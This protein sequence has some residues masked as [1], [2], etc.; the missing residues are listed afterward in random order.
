ME[1]NLSRYLRSFPLASA[2]SMH[3]AID[4]QND[5]SNCELVDLGSKRTRIAK[6]LHGLFCTG[7]L[8]A[9]LESR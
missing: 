5:P 4:I 9:T 1:F 7:R 6:I 3:L 8:G 2:L